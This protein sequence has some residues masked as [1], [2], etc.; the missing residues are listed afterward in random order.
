MPS[1]PPASSPFSGPVKR[2][3]R[4]SSVAT[5]ACVAGCSPHPGVHRGRDTIGPRIRGGRA[6]QV[7]GDAVRELGERRSPWPARS[8][9]VGV[10]REAGRAARASALPQRSRNGLPVRRGEVAAPT[11]RVA[12]AVRTCD[13]GARVAGAG[14]RGSG[15]VGGD[16]AGDPEQ[17]AAAAKASRSVDR[18]SPRD[19]RRRSSP[20]RSPRGRWKAACAADAGLDER[21]D[22]LAAALAELAVVGVD[23]PR[24]LRGQDHQGV[25]GVDGWR[26][27]RRS[28]VRSSGMHSCRWIS[29]R[30]ILWMI[31]AT[32][33]AALSTSSF[34][35]TWSNQPACSSSRAAAASRSP[36]ASSSV[37]GPRSR[38]LE[39]S[40]EGGTRKIS[41]ASGTSRTRAP[42]GRRSPAA[43]PGRRRGR[44]RTRAGVPDRSSEDLAHSRSSP[45]AIIRSN[46]VG[47]EPVVDAV[48]LARPRWP[49]RR[50]MESDES[51]R[52]AREQAFERRVPFPTPEGPARTISLPVPYGACVYFLPNLVSSSSRCLHPARGCGGCGDVELLHD[53][54]GP[55]L[56][57][58]G[59][60]LEHRRHLHLAQRVVLVGLLEQIG[61]RAL[62]GLELPLDLGALLTRG[63]PPS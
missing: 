41:T 37:P 15:L 40:S 25:L 42:P 58:A 39:L 55:D 26:A 62:A 61:Q 57:D 50:G 48:D 51:A 2:T 6:Q 14:A 9:E 21:R 53:L 3:P 34:T 5:L 36:I 20:R 22:E 18:R 60:R 44:P 30:G 17:H 24:A 47:D 35:T 13:V 10:M 19:A 27:G 32:S 52:I 33:S 7:V 8:G 28:W 11:N 4:A 56:A 23:L 59:E 12:D 31:A 16:A 46:R 49:R 54:L 43:R 38:A 29:G 45:A 63:S 1:S